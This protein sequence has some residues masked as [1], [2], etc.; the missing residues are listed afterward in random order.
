M[1]RASASRVR[2]TLL[3]T[4]PGGDIQVRREFGGVRASVTAADNSA[5][6]F[7]TDGSG[8]LAAML[9]IDSEPLTGRTAHE[10]E[11]TAS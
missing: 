10:Q 1:N 2:E 6:H 4:Y 5:V 11:S 9:G 8:V 7:K 3:R